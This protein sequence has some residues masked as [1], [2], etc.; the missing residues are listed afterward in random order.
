MIERT[1]VF[2][3]ASR[4]CLELPGHWLLSLLPNPPAGFALCSPSTKEAVVFDPRA[5]VVHVRGEERRS[6]YHPRSDVA[7]IPDYMAEWMRDNP[8]WP[9]D[10]DLSMFTP[11]TLAE[12]Q[13]LES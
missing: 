9:D 8:R 1:L 3:P 2:Y 4:I 12:L 5:V 10:T 7:A 13:G 11:A 6:V